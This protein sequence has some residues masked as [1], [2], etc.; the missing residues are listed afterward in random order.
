MRHEFLEVTINNDIISEPEYLEELAKY[1]TMATAH[2]AR[3]IQEHLGFTFL[4]SWARLLFVH[5]HKC[6]LIRLLS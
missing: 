6:S 2:E 4:A 1:N 5:S 3:T